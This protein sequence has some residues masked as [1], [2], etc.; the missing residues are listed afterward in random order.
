VRVLPY[1]E[2]HTPY[3]SLDRNLGSV[4]VF[5]TPSGTIVHTTLI[6][7]GPQAVAVD[8]QTGQSVV[9]CQPADPHTG[10]PR[11]PARLTLLDGASGRPVRGVILPHMG[12]A[13]SIGIDQHQ[14]VQR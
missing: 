8:D 7:Q 1:R 2:P 6:N 4:P 10:S 11:G 3:Y 13:I 12:G 5:D 9:V 14:L